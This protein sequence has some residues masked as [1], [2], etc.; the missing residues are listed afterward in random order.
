MTL[1]GI[2]VVILVLL[3]VCLVPNSFEMVLLNLDYN[4]ELKLLANK[5]PFSIYLNPLTSYLGYVII[6]ALYLDVKK[7]IFS[8][9]WIN[10]YIMAILIFIIIVLSGATVFLLNLYNKEK[11]K[12]ITFEKFLARI[13]K[14]AKEVR[15]G[16]LSRRLR[17]SLTD[18]TKS[19]AKDINNM[20]ETLNDRE[21]MIKAYQAELEGQ[22]ANLEAMV[23]MQEDFTA[24]LTHDLKV[25]ILAEINALKLLE[26]EQLGEISENQK[27]AIQT[28]L[29]S[30]EEL[31]FLVNTLLD[32]Y[33]IQS[34]GVKITKSNECMVQIVNECISEV[35]FLLQ[36]QTISF[37]MHF[38]HLKISVDKIEIKRV[39]KNLLSNAI[40]H[41][42]QNG[43]IEIFLE[44]DDDIV[45]V[46]VVDDGKGIAEND[47]KKVFEKYF[48]T[49]KKF[50]KVGTGLGL[51]LSKLIVE[52]HDGEIGVE[53]KEN[54][55][56]K[57]YFTLPLN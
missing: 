33:K 14:T 57:F 19:I 20:I 11:K 32:T 21:V 31:L 16:N 48:S 55:G 12:N 40:T 42:N 29:K 56:S 47:L 34:E 10:I 45:K 24:T 13:S 41:T 26:K 4:I 7:F 37:P 6:T 44:K 8:N 18:E 51:Y 36:G 2:V 28:M 25:P 17:S 1:S 9:F 15:Y 50:R 38:N 39:I 43:K 23:T 54:I 22:K 35:S 30:N 53:S 49:N 27:V 5:A 52:K 3:V 46:T